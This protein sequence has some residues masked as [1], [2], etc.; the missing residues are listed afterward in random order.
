MS[1]W[2]GSDALGAAISEIE[3]EEYSDR[4][5]GSE[6]GSGSDSGTECSGSEGSSY[7]SGGSSEEG[8]EEDDGA[9][10][11][12]MADDDAE[13]ALVC[14]KEAPLAQT[15][16]QGA[17]PAGSTVAV[18]AAGRLYVADGDRVLVGDSRAA[19]PVAGARA[20]GPFGA[21]VTGVSV[22]ARGTLVAVTTSAPAL[23]VCLARTGAPL[24]APVAGAVWAQF[25]PRAAAERTLLVRR[26]AALELCTAT[27]A[28]LAEPAAVLAPAAASAAWAPDGRRIAVLRADAPAAPLAVC[29][30]SSAGP[31]VWRSTP[32]PARPVRVL[33]P[34]DGLLCVVTAPEGAGNDKED[35]RNADLLATDPD[36]HSDGSRWAFESVYCNPGVSAREE[37]FAVPLLRCYVVLFGTRADVPL[38]VL[39]RRAH[40]WRTVTVDDSCLPYFN[41]AYPVGVAVAAAADDDSDTVF[42]RLDT[43]AL[44]RVAA[45]GTAPGALPP[46]ATLPVDDDGA[47]KEEEEEE[48]E[49][50]EE[51]M[52]HE[53]CFAA[54]ERV[55]ELWAAGREC[56]AACRTGE[57][58]ASALAQLRVGVAMARA[59]ARLD[60]RAHVQ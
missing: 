47:D 37:V 46:V 31:V 32:V 60:G 35:A 7:G 18:D 15:A 48:E 45:T 43:G 24:A 34:A 11:P 50:E 19:A 3:D 25:C 27:P 54:L 8:A 53:N 1:N 14:R 22:S 41:E 56:V 57:D 28:G 23:H 4:D 36:A 52:P 17:P 33:W 26:A 38:A 44:C 6:S 30:V 20:L 5:S 59:A 39:L 9:Q 29:D 21:P 13:G 51:D 42:V 16:A 40:G 55:A 2:S 10:P 58:A 49:G 12:E